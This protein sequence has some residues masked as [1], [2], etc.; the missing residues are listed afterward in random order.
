M[1]NQVAVTEAVKWDDDDDDDDDASLKFINFHYGP[2][3]QLVS[4]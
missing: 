1:Q 4:V 2:M 3:C